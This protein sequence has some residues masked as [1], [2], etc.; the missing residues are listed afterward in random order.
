MAPDLGWE[1]NGPAF[2]PTPAL[3]EFNYIDAED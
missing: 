1:G 2:A 3:R